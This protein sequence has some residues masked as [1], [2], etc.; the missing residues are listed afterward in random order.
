MEPRRIGQLGA[1]CLVLCCVI[2][3]FSCRKAEDEQPKKEIAIVK[4]KEVLEFGF[5]LNNFI[6]KRD[7]IKSGDSF[8]EILERNNIGYPRIFEIAEKTKDT[9]DIRRLRAGKPYTI[10]CAKDS[11]QTPKTFIYQPNKIDYVVIKP[12]GFHKCLY[13]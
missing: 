10:L 13:R 5:N 11:L 3:T 7:T 9:F 2:F 1:R 6:V 8:G 12:Q 4:P